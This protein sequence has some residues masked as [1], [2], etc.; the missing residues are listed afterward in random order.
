MRTGGKDWKKFASFPPMLYPT[1][2]TAFILSVTFRRMTEVSC[3]GFVDDHEDGIFRS[4]IS[5]WS[6]IFSDE[7]GMFR[8]SDGGIVRINEFRRV[9]AGEPRMSEDRMSILG[10]LG[11]YQEM[12]GKSIWTHFETLGNI[13]KDGEI[14]YENVGKL[15]KIRNHDVS[16]IH[17]HKGV[18]ITE[19]NLGDLPREYIGRKHIGLSSVQPVESLP[20]EFVGIGTGHGGTHQFLVVDFVEACVTHKLP[21]NNIWLASRYNVPGIMAHES[22]KLG[23]ELLKIPDFGMPPSDWELMDPASALKE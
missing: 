20:K 3:F 22:S 5:Q 19:E 2:S 11:S 23:G 14:D 7:S 15:L 6:N 8:T 18:E 21:P 17:E 9:C 4:D 1:H 10:T 13:R 12:P 16:A